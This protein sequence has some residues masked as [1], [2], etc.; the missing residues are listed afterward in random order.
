[1]AEKQAIFISSVKSEKTTTV[2]T[3]SASSSVTSKP[4]TS[5]VKDSTADMKA[6]SGGS[7]LADFL[8]HLEDYT[9]TVRCLPC[10]YFC[11]F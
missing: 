7:S 5:N 9:P 2:S 1:M 3:P 6:K 10:S 4:S 11:R 8:L